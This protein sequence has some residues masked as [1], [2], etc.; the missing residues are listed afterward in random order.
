MI[1]GSFMDVKMD[2]YREITDHE[3]LVEKFKDFLFDFNAMSKRQ[4]NLVLFLAFATHVARLVRVLNLPLGNALCVG[5]GGSGRKSV[6]TLASFVVDFDLYQI[7]IS[8]NY[9]N[10]DWLEDMKRLLMNCGTK[11]QRTT[12]LFSDTQVQKETFLEDILE[13][14]KHQLHADSPCRLQE[15]GGWNRAK[16]QVQR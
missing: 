7:E 12:F 4:M 13:L 5:V 11:Q 6:T 9:G 1:W 16:F 3:A 10:P 2:T 14:T 8:K 15:N